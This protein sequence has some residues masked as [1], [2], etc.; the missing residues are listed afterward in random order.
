MGNK[1]KE[2]GLDTSTEMEEAEKGQEKDSLFP[3]ETAPPMDPSK[4]PPV[5]VD[6]P[7]AWAPAIKV[8]AE[9]VIHR[10][11]GHDLVF[12]LQG[13]P[14]HL[15]DKIEKAC[16]AMD[17]PK[18]EIPVLDNRQRPS[19]GQPAQTVDDFDDPE[20]KD[21]L[22]EMGRQRVV[23]YIDAALTFDIPGKSWQEKAKWLSERI[24]GE[25][26]KLYQFIIYDF[27][28]LYTAVE[29]FR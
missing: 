3:D 26:L 7:D 1:E 14:G 29:G 16:Q 25:T 11:G 5:V 9:F 17:P 15:N 18:K 13:I 10:P 28:N 27:L 24:P 22:V 4:L 6:S 20:Y 23:L 12:Q 19:L 2:E 21:H 8:K